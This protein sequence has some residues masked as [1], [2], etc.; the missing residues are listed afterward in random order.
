MLDSRSVA[1]A[2]ATAEMRFILISSVLFCLVFIPVSGID[3]SAELKRR[4][5]QGIGFWGFFTFNTAIYSYIGQLFMCSVR[6]QGTA[7][8]LASIF[9]GINNFFS[10]LIVRPQQ[11]IGLWKFT[12]WINPGH[13]VYE[14]LCMVVFSR[15]KNRFV[16]VA[17]GSDY[18]DE[19]CVGLG[20]LGPCQVTVAT[21]VNAFFGG[22][23]KE[24][25]IPRNI[26]ILGAILFLVRTNSNDMG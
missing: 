23:Y 4:A 12:Y 10:G 17:N 13:Y 26:I 2:L 6:G 11:M 25:N 1:R 7:Q 8:I 20:S 19:L 5:A 16:T 22:L 24:E 14:G 3:S 18:Y 15:D 21:Y 9:I